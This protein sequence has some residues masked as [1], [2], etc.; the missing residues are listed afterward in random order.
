MIWAEGEMGAL[1]LLIVCG[2]A[3]FLFLNRKRTKN[4]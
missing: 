1:P 2:S 3:L 4:E